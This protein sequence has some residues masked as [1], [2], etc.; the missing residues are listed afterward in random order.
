[1]AAK[2]RNRG[3][4]G[5]PRNRIGVPFSTSG[6]RTVTSRKVDRIE[7]Q[8]KGAT[9]R[10]SSPYAAGGPSGLSSPLASAGGALAP[11]GSVRRR[12]RR[13]IVIAVLAL[14]LGALCIAYPF[15]SDAI[16][17]AREKSVIEASA[18]VVEDTDEDTLAAEREK[19]V[20]YNRQLLD[21][22]AVVTDPFDPDAERPTD[23][24]YDNVMNLAGDGVMGTINIP[25]IH[26]ELP[27]Y[28]SVDDDVL[29]HG[30][31]HL[32]GTSVPIGGESTHAV[33]SGH[34]G[35][36]SMKIFDN[37]D[38]LKEGDYF[39]LSVLGEDH[40]YEVTS[41]ETV[42]PDETDSLV[43]EE[44][45]DLCTLVTCTPYGVNT[46]RLLVHAERCE[47]PE[48]W[49][50]KGDADFPSGY[51]EPPDK[52]LLPSVLL[53]LVLAAVVIG[54]YTGI[55]K[56]RARRA[57]ARAAEEAALRGGAAGGAAAA[58]SLKPLTGPLPGNPYG[59]SPGPD[60][61]LA[62][63]AAKA[64]A[65]VIP[66]GRDRRAGAGGGVAGAAADGATPAGGSHASGGVSCASA[67]HADHA[68]GAA[69][70]AGR[71]AGKRFKPASD[72][73]GASAGSSQPAIGNQ[74]KRP[75]QGSPNPRGHHFK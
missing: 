54:G 8:G 49:L 11:D 31:G 18:V 48:E 7:S 61:G 27:V 59:R 72:S 29:E 15:V 38:Q 69:S 14:L 42:L 34:T 9:G 56:L 50:D 46:H 60:A 75:D 44:G 45:R 2:H 39:V 12:G 17:Q 20:E 30:V 62:D 10:D 37:L 13:Q 28:H 57:E 68:A 4:T 58:G 43:I 16:N 24:D 65:P 36:P 33:L 70:T 22:R 71:P 51:S 52:A 32:E 47:V 5:Q 6:R 66:A 73:A 35:L 23:E 25:A 67:S 3:T 26:V 63:S 74:G 40:A 19:A 53:G 64:G 55:S 1:M 21:G 41:I